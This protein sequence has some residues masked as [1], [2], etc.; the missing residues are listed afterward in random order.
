MC[1]FSRFITFPFS[2]SILAKDITRTRHVYEKTR[3]K[4]DQDSTGEVGGQPFSEMYEIVGG[5]SRVSKK[6]RGECEGRW[7]R[8]RRRY[9]KVRILGRMRR[10][11]QEAYRPIGIMSKRKIRRGKKK[12]RR[13]NTRVDNKVTQDRRFLPIDSV[14]VSLPE[15]DS[16]PSLSLRMFFPWNRE[17]QPERKREKGTRLKAIN[18]WI[19]YRVDSTWPE[20]M[21][22]DIVRE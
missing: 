14:C 15:N 20:V 18:F 3:L 17:P 13:T 19:I 7:E 2:L 1:V 22:L 6:V 4:V 8:R 12:R 9:G 21:K 10:I 11:R 5:E 16:S